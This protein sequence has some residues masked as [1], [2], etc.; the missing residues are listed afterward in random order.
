MELR[1]ASA[2]AQQQL[3]GDR[4]HESRMD[5]YLRSLGFYRKKVAKD[6]SCLFRAV[7]E[8]VLHCQGLH[9]QVRVTCVDYLRRNRSTYELFIEGN[10]EKY[11]ENLQDPQSWVGQVEI[12]ALAE[13]YKHDFVI[14][15]EP[16]QPPVNITENGFT[17]KVR[18]C[19]LN[20]NHYDSVY[21]QSF[22]KSA[23]VCQSI[24]YEL[25]Y[26]RVC[27]VER[28]ILGPC[29]KGGKGRDKLDSE[30]C[31]SSEESDLEEDE[32]W[33]SEPREK[34]TNGM[35]VRP[36]QRGR[37]R[38]HSRG[39]GCDL[40]STK[41]QKSLNPAFYRNVEYDV[42]L[43]SKRIQQQRD[44]CM[45][46]GMQYSVGDKCKV[47]L[48]NRFY[49]AYVQEVSPDNGPV[50]VF[51]GE[52]NK[53]ETVPLL[54]LRLPSEETQSWQTAEKGKRHGA[55]NN[56][57][58]TSS[59]WES[60]G[61]R[62]SNKMPS[63]SAPS[64][65][66]HKQ[67][68]WPPQ[69]TSDDTK[70]KFRRSNQRSSPV[71]VLPE[72]ESAILEL[73]HKDEHNFPS[74]GTSPQ[75]ATASEV[76]K[77]GGEKRGSR[78]KDQKEHISE[79]ETPQRPVQRQKSATEEKHGIKVSEEPGQKS[80][81]TIKENVQEK[82]IPASPSPSP[83]PAVIV[84]SDPKKAP[85][86][87][88][89]ESAKALGPNQSAPEAIKKTPIPPK[90]NSARSPDS[91]QFA[92]V[93]TSAPS[94]SISVAG[95]VSGTTP[96]TIQSMPAP[97]PTQPSSQTVPV[98]TVV[99]PI[100]DLNS[101]PT[102]TPS[103]ISSVASQITPVQVPAAILTQT[104]LAPSGLVPRASV[105]P[106]PS[107]QT[108][109]PASIS[110]PPCIPASAIP[111]SAPAQVP[112]PMLDAPDPFS[113]TLPIDAS[114]GPPIGEKTVDPH[115]T[116][117]PIPLSYDPP[118][119]ISPSSGPAHAPPPDL[120]QSSFNS[121][122]PRPCETAMPAS[123]VAPAPELPSQPQQLPYPHVQWSQ[124]LQDPVYPGFPK[125]EKGEVEPLPPYS[126]SQKGEDLPQDINILRFFFNL[127]VKAY[128]QPMFPPIVYLGALNQAYQM[129]LRGPPPSS[130]SPANP[131]VTSWQPENPSPPRNLSSIPDTSLDSHA[132]VA[133][134]ASGS[135][136]VGP[137]ELGAYNDHPV[138]IPMLLPQRPPMAWPA[139]SGLST[140]A[141]SY[142]P[143]Q[144]S[145]PPY[146]PPGN[147]M[148]PPS[149]VGYHRM[150]LPMPLEALNHG[151]HGRM[152]F[153]P[154][155]PPTVDR[156][157]GN[158]QRSV[159]PQFGSLQNTAGF[160]GGQPHLSGGD[161]KPLDIPVSVA[162]MEPPPFSGHCPVAQPFQIGPL[163]GDMAGLTH[164]TN[165]NLGKQGGLFP[166][167]LH[168]GLIAE[169][170]S[171]SIH[172]YSPN[173][174]WSVEEMEFHNVDLST[175]QSFY[176][177]SYRGGGRRGQDDRGGYRGRSH[178]GWKDYSGRGRQDEQ[179]FY[180]NYVRR[181]AGP[182]V[183]MQLPYP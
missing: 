18:L 82:P 39:R 31:K 162:T 143:V 75:T 127:G 171:R 43:R 161:Y 64:G 137:I 134:V 163:Q 126:F 119:S 54:S 33:S 78:K 40:L 53:Q 167:S 98:P 21:P 72:E 58:Q 121:S 129:H 68:S 99:L 86:S 92:P 156:G 175:T 60:R 73:L 7:A 51:I 48:N 79:T 123:G 96:A 104:T 153:L 131:T 47:Q 74:L 9:T 158:G 140:Y 113:T 41:A 19:F 176:S 4:T 1:A 172:P 120:P 61:S 46:A 28:S 147:Q 84:S 89:S 130:D 169:D 32:F 8:Q 136:P 5:E 69:A 81:S 85:S 88:Q 26:D 152:D 49:N 38:G 11:L 115:T 183:E 145:A 178:R 56:S 133:P 100:P 93:S 124:L 42:W 128:S 55:P 20:G 110:A 112:A 63:Q 14:F 50:T 148:Y 65:R 101:Q 71:C 59:E 116:V 111:V 13:L 122:D 95:A 138:S 151:P 157:Q 109:S 102:Q 94:Q 66:V 83:P 37:G 106:T 87:S 166:K 62:R 52:L 125:N 105:E 97:K 180:R 70:N 30:E 35:N 36:P 150:P 27:G 142:S 144:F 17:K 179:S 164:L 182:R 141:G 44:F 29:M 2:D 159:N 107:I 24:L 173:D 139:S 154:F 77:K 146:P 10:F 15:Q 25:L 45:A 76:I 135:G 155:V 103:Q 16:D 34:P 67:H 23:A 6:G 80:S 118:T 149:S 3:A 108:A 170:P 177:Q 114:S 12:T 22:E 91:S 174:K 132:P 168:A 160:P 57:T 117:T 165:G 181:G 90:A